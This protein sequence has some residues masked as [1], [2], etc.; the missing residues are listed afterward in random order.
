MVAI[1]SRATVSQQVDGSRYGVEF[2]D[3]WAES[4]TRKSARV[5]LVYDE[6]R[7]YQG[8]WIDYDADVL[9]PVEWD[10]E[11]LRLVVS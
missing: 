5:A 7:D 4:D 8:G 10:E 6:E 1:D 9:E 3:I 2:Y 11:P